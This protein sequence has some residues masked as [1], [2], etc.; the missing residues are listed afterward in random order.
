MYLEV[1]QRH[2]LPIS[3]L[4]VRSDWSG[5]RT[6]L[7]PQSPIPHLGI[8]KAQIEVS[9]MKGNCS[10]YNIIGQAI[11][12]FL[13]AYDVLVFCSIFASTYINHTQSKTCPF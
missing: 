7:Q 4:L 9:N 8:S 11:G 3:T 13:D 5:E 10:G 12:N 1:I 6:W 2:R